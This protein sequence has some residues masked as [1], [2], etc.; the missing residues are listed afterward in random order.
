MR[1]IFKRKRWIRTKRI[2]GDCTHLT[3][4][5]VSLQ[6]YESQGRYVEAAKIQEEVLDKRRRIL[7][8]IIHTHS[9]L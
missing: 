1:Q 3:A 7:G 6:T 8:M 4:T 9:A 5:I 2:W